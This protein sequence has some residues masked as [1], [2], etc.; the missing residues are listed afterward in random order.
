MGGVAPRDLQ[1]TVEMRWVDFNIPSTSTNLLLPS[2]AYSTQIP[3]T[4]SHCP[5]DRLYRMK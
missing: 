1:E 2:S 4:A 5:D 3:S